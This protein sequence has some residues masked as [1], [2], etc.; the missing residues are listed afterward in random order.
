MFF[1][2]DGYPATLALAASLCSLVSGCSQTHSHSRSQDFCIHISGAGGMTIAAGIGL[3]A[4]VKVVIVM[5]AATIVAMVIGVAIVDQVDVTEVTV[6]V[7]PA[8]E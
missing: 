1:H 8:V 2:G 6:A 7:A 3:V 4:I 5:I